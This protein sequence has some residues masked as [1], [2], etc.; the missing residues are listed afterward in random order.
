MTIE[1]EAF[2][3]GYLLGGLPSE[4]YSAR[5]RVNKWNILSVADQERKMIDDL[6]QHSFDFSDQV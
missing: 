3:G 2:I 1:H 6:D 4:A 5:G